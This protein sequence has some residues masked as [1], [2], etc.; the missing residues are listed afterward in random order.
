LSQVRRLRRERGDE[1]VDAVFDDSEPRGPRAVADDELEL[2]SGLKLLDL[3]TRP[4]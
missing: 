3:Q 1:L 4:F 2:L